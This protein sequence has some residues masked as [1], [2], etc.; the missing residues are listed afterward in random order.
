M[1]LGG[2]DVHDVHQ[3]P[4]NNLHLLSLMRVHW[5]PKPALMFKMQ[6][7]RLWYL[8]MIGAVLNVI[9]QHLDLKQFSNWLSL[10]WV[11]ND[12]EDRAADT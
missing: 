6:S 3:I 1:K 9:L 11:L 10:L 5:R 7:A 12:V 2:H 4:E 8:G